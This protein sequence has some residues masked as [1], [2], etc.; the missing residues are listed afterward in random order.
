M[1]KKEFC[2]GLKRILS[3]IKKRTLSWI[4]K[5]FVINNNNNLLLGGSITKSG[6]HRGPTERILSWIKKNF[7][8]D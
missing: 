5:D 6:L 1:D 4:K 3:W 8:I 7:V 2:H